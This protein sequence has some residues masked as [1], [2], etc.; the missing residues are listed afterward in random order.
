MRPGRGAQVHGKPRPFKDETGRPFDNVYYGRGYV[1]LTWYDNYKQMDQ[2]LA[3][4]ELLEQNPDKAMDPPMAY[5]IM[6]IGVRE[7]L[8]GSH[9]VQ[10]PPPG[11]RTPG[12]RPTATASR[13]SWAI[14]SSPGSATTSTPACA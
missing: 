13:P 9:Y 14:S 4:G 10:A 6:S 2:R 7:G 1:Q 5:R 3:L 12:R 8:F 11:T